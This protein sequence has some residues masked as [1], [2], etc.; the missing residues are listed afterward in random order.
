[1]KKAN[2]NTLQCMYIVYIVMYVECIHFDVCGMY[3]Y[4][5]IPFI[6]R[7]KTGKTDL[8]C[9]KAGLWL[10][11]RARAVIA[12]GAGEISGS[13]NIPL[14]DLDIGY[15]GKNALSC[16]FMTRVLFFICIIF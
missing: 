7:T 10:P 6:Q 4:S 11:L 13:G 15:F 12:K 2:Q 14:F 1:M 3:V 9:E 5:T 8:W 16:T